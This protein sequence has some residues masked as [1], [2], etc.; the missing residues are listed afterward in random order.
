M[1]R[2]G[3]AKFFRVNASG[4][5]QIDACGAADTGIGIHFE[6][7]NELHVGSPIGEID[8]PNPCNFRAAA[9]AQ[10]AEN[11]VIVSGR[12]SGFFDAEISGYLLHP[13]HVRTPG[14]Q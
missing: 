11:T 5:A 3:L 13:G 7:G 6:W 14:Q 10:A 4:R 8:G 12:E 2:W 1:G 9:N